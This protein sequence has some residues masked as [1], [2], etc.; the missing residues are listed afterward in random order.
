MYAL[1]MNIEVSEQ[2]IYN[3]PTNE[4]KQCHYEERIIE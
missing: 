2:H 3:K 1:P 4:E